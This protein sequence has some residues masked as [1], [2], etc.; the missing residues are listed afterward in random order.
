MDKK[1]KDFKINPIFKDLNLGWYRENN[2]GGTVAGTYIHGIFE[3]DNW[4]DQYLNLIRKKRK[5][6]TLEKKTRSYI[7]KR[8]TIINNLAKEFNKH[9]NISSLLN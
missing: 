6:P 1:Q 9:L 7:I 8:E 3:N 5:L 4:R 2:E